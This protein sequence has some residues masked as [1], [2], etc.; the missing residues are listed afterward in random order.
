MIK[1]WGGVLMERRIG[2][3]H[4]FGLTATMLS[5]AFLLVLI[6]FVGTIKA[7]QSSDFIIE[8]DHHVAQLM[9]FFRSP[10]INIVFYWIT[11]LGSVQIVI[12]L[13]IVAGLIFSLLRKTILILPLVASSLS[14]FTITY[15]GKLAFHRLRPDEALL[16][17]HSYSFPSGHSTQAVALYGFITYILICHSRRWISRINLFLIGTFVILLI[18]SSRMILGVHYLSDVWAG[19]LVG[20][21][22]LILGISITKWLIAKDKHTWEHSFSTNSKIIAWLVFAVFLLYYASASSLY[23]APWLEPL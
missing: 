1:K 3:S 8:A 15:F 9:T 14:A 10:K 2:K 19:Y 17:E 12:P 5:L 4:F 16:L 7:V 23:P 13:I 20:S 11:E 18:G 6:L 21:L 22:G